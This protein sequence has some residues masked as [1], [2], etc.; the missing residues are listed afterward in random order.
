MER[1]EKYIYCDYDVECMM[2]LA[3]Q[4]EFLFKDKGMLI[5]LY[6]E[7]IMNIYEDYKNYDDNNMSLLDSVN[8]YINEHEQEIISKMSKSFE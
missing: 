3:L 6:C 2:Y 5:D 1:K 7:A 4:I 8:K